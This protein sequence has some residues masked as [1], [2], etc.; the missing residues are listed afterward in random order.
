MQGSPTRDPETSRREKS[1][2][3]TVSVGILLFVVGFLITLAVVESDHAAASDNDTS[4]QGSETGSS[5]STG[6]Y[7]LSGILI[8]LVGVVLATVGPVAGMVKGRF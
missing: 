1:R 8:S 6:L 5:T 7:L 4:G 3:I 2:L